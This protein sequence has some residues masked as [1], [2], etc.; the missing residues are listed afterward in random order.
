MN[1]VVILVLAF[2]LLVSISGCTTKSEY[3]K[4]FNEK[5][6]IEKECTQLTQENAR[7][8]DQISTL[9]KVKEDLAKL[10]Q[11][12]ARL[13]DKSSTLQTEKEGLAEQLKQITTKVNNLNN[14]LSKVRTKSETLQQ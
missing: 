3:D 10:T 6:S 1:R 5:A 13:K 9:Q 2:G 14:E 12:N 8:E 7:L 11:E 4:L